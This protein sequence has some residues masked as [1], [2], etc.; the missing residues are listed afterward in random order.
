MM[1]IGMK[2]LERK[3]GGVAQN[4]IGSDI[5]NNKNKKLI[6]DLLKSVD[7]PVTANLVRDRLYDFWGRNVPTCR[8]LGTFMNIHTNMQRT[9]KKSG[10][11]E[12]LWS[13]LNE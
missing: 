9:D 1:K 11:A 8:E 10:A 6:E 4:M 12:Y 5:M 2:F 13:D 3:I 7:Y